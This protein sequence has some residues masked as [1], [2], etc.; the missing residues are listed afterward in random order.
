M[1]LNMALVLVVAFVA[2]ATV[3]RR[4]NRAEIGDG[5]G[6]GR[7]GILGQGSART[8]GPG[9]DDV[10]TGVVLDLAGAALGAGISIPT[11]LR[12]LAEA[13]GSSAAGKGSRA[14]AD[15]RNLS[16]VANSLLMGATWPEAWEDTRSSHGRLRD[17]LEPAW[18][19]GAAPVPLL[20]RSAATLRAARHRLAQEAAARLGAKL[21]L[22]L[23]LCFLPAF[24]VLGIVPVVASAGLMIFGK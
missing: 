8:R 15:Q 19:D 2:L 5:A 14:Q 7:A 4:A 12:A 20:E 17:S 16:D 10:D 18:V 3:P 9:V 24:I 23:G 11:M 21:A 1:T 22:P 6:D 13:L